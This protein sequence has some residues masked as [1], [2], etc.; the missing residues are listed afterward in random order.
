M[1]L[2]HAVVWI[3]HHGAKLLQ[4]DAAQVQVRHLQEHSH[5]TRQHGSGVRSE[6]EFFG[7]VCNSLAGTVE[8]LVTGPHT[9]LSDFRH[10]VTK[11]RPASAAQIVGWEI[12]DHPTEGQLLA[13]A[14]RYFDRRL[15]S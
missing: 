11:H 5:N 6:H 10:Y 14:R 9:A 13:L 7:E 3:D 1:S 4:F 8:V 12:T 15:E 2:F